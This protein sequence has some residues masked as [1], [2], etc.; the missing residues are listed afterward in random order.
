MLVY[1]VGLG[2]GKCACVTFIDGVG[3]GDG[4][5]VGD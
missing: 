2:G 5:I 4:S 3:Q 1:V